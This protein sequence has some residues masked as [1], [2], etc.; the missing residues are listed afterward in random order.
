MDSIE[1]AL[2]AKNSIFARVASGLRMV[3]NF[4]PFLFFN[5]FSVTGPRIYTWFINLRASEPNKKIGAAGFCWGGKWT[6]YLSSPAEAN[7]LTL[8][9]FKAAQA[10][11]T[12]VVTLDASKPLV[13]AGY[14][15]HP[16]MLDVPTDAERVVSPVSVANGSEDMQVTKDKAPLLQAAFSK[17]NA[18]AGEEKYVYTNYEGAKH[19]FAVRWDT[20]DEQQNKQAAEAEAQAIAFFQ[21]WLV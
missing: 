4:V 17:L 2:S 12:N 18:E 16:S 15:A 9:F 13:D 5:R 19:G 10:N 11:V 21:K 3:A 1:V 7:P 6:F 8:G 14:T 20:K